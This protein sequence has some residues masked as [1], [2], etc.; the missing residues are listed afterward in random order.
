MHKLLLLP[1]DGIG[2]E[3]MAEAVKVLDALRQDFPFECETELVGGAAIDA[4]GLPFPDKTRDKALAA[5]AVLFGTV[6]GPKWDHMPTEKR[7]EMGI[8]GIRKAMQLYANLRPIDLF[9]ELESLSPLKAE[10]IKGVSLIVVRELTGDVYF[11]RP[12][13]VTGENGNREGFNTMRY[14]ED[15]IKRIAHTAFKLARERR[16]KVCSIDKSNVLEAM[17]LWKA[18]VSEV[19]AGYPDVELSHMYVD[20]ASMQLI[21]RAA[22]FDVVLTP[23]MFGDILSDEAS[24]L[25]GSLGLSPSASLGE[26]NALYE[27]IHGSA[28][29]IA[30]KGIA[31][32][33][34]MIL[35]VAMMYELSF[36][37]KDLAQRVREGVAKTLAEGYR[38]ADIMTPGGKK[39]NTSEMGSQIASRL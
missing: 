14:H 23:N 34:G 28:P 4:C 35:S 17:G 5:E 25:A 19:H 33:V 29:D 32:P 12:R 9:P 8:L 11:G 3:I 18:V 1:G 10:F 7:A 21:R 38:T 37:R 13:G 15:E 2:T 22:D 20:N 6:G 27:P 16:K 26:N 24:V 30:G 39:V 31:N 36:G